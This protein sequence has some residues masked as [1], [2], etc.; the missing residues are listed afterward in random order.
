M[1]HRR[2]FLPPPTSEEDL[3]SCV[4]QVLQ[5][6]L[7]LLGGVHGVTKVLQQGRVPQQAPLLLQPLVV[8]LQA[9]AC[10]LCPGQDVLFVDHRG[11]HL[12]QLLSLGP[13]LCLAPAKLLFYV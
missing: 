2:P 12:C 3:C 13:D 7:Q 4:L 8:L 5:A 10:L 11:L 1:R 6:F 9:F